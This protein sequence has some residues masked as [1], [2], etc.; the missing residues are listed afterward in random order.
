MT[1]QTN[2]KLKTFFY[3]V[4]ATGEIKQAM[5]KG[6]KPK[7]FASMKGTLTTNDG[8]SK[9]RTITVFNTVKNPNLVADVVALLAAGPA[10]LVIAFDRGT[11]ENKGETA[12]VVGIGR[13]NASNDGAEPLDQ[14]A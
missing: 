9:A 1:D 10:R 13:V 12:R 3:T 5:T 6:D 14:A 4:A 8:K 7:P 11:G 2:A